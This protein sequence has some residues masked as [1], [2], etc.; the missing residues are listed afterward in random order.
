MVQVL[1][2]TVEEDPKV[3]KDTAGSTRA[4]GLDV[5]GLESNVTQELTSVT[6]KDSGFSSS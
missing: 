5:K 6:S 1:V 3:V 4:E 2:G